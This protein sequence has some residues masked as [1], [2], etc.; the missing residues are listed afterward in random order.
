M[1]MKVDGSP[2]N[3]EDGGRENDEGGWLSPGK[4]GGDQR[5]QR[6]RCLPVAGGS[7]LALKHHIHPHIIHVIFANMII[8]YHHPPIKNID[9]MKNHHRHC[10]CYPPFT[11]GSMVGVHRW[12]AHTNGPPKEVERR[13]DGQRRARKGRRERA[14]NGITG[15]K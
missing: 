9:S 10:C 15:E 13:A 2:G 3:L 11:A 14:K 1:M 8:D 12:A 7:K 5:R 6:R 4:R